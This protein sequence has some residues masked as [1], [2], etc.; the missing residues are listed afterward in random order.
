MADLEKCVA[1][2]FFTPDQVFKT[3][4]RI[5][6][7]SGR[8]FDEFWSPKILYKLSGRPFKHSAFAL[9]HCVFSI[10]KIKIKTN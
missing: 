10:K 5:F 9:K 3:P 1:F 8:M 2:A 7:I 6:Q 4:G